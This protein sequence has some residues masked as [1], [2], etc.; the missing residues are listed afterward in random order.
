MRLE[1]AQGDLLNRSDVED[2][3]FAGATFDVRF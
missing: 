3:P 2:A 1:D